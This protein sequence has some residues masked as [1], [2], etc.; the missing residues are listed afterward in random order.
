MLK[1]NTS[2]PPVSILSKD[3][4]S[5][6]DSSCITKE[7]KATNTNQILA[8]NLTKAYIHKW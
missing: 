8:D 7:S 1:N 2:M 4:T 3:S 6:G 5:V